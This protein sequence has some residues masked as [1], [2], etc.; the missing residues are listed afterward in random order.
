MYIYVGGET[1]IVP[2]LEEGGG[3]HISLAKLEVS[4]PPLLCF[5]VRYT[6]KTIIIPFAKGVVN[7]YG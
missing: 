2:T 7:N 5:L 4:T 3:T 1:Q 6:I